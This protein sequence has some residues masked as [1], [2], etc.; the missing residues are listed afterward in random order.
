MAI[1]VEAG[2][3]GD[4]ADAG[5][6]EELVGEALVEFRIGEVRGDYRGRLGRH[7]ERLFIVENA[8]A[9]DDGHIECAAGFV[10]DDFGNL[11]ENLFRKCAL[12]LIGGGALR[13]IWH[14]ARV[15]HHFRQHF[16]RQRG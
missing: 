6:G 5:G 3:E 11:R 16:L 10:N 7:G 15:A 9:E 13:E 12:A 4:D 8:V 1:G 14:V 2:G